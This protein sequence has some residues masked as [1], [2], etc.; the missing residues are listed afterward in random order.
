MNMLK[1]QKLRSHLRARPSLA[2]I[3]VFLK[4]VETRS[5]VGAAKLIGISQPAV[6][7][8]IAKL[9]AFYPGHLFVRRRSMP[10]MLTPVG[11]ALLPL[12]E[13]MLHAADQSI[14]RTDAA[15]NSRH[16]RLSIGFYP[17]IANGPLPPARSAAGR[18]GKEEINTG[19]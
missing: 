13:A 11:E 8:A 1:P 14:L 9:E 17:G 10:L 6:S 15:S 2:Q 4:V 3:E 7:Q 16:G 5:F 18:E 19:R 12:A